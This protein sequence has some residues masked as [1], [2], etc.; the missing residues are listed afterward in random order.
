MGLENLKSIFEEELNNSIDDFSS[1]VITNV[2]GTK[3][4]STPP[5]PPSRVATNPTDFSSAV[6][7]N[8]LPFTPLNQLG[9][10]FLDGLSWEKLYNPNHSYKDD[11]VQSENS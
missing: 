3:F 8:D 4:F 9:N 2:D 6:G 11:A 10:S 7:N 5:Q 1:N